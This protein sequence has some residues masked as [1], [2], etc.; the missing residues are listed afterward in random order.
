MC[1]SL[2]VCVNLTTS[3][4]PGDPNPLSSK[5]SLKCWI[6]LLLPLLLLLLLLLPLPPPLLPLLE[7][8]E[9]QDNSGTDDM[10]GIR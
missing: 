10:R 7:L 3:A 5:F 6:T 8:I 1:F 2:R 9:T 4:S